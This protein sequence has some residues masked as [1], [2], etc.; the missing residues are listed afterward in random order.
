[1]FV[2]YEEID[3]FL[4]PEHFKTLKDLKLENVKKDEIKIYSNR[5][6]KNGEINGS[7][8]NNSLIQELFENYHN[9]AL[10]LLRKLNNN[11]IELWDYSEFHIIE[12]GSHYK[13]PIHRDSPFKILSG[14]I[15]ISPEI[16]KGTLLFSNMS[17][18]D[19]KE[20]LWEP[21]KALFFSRDENNSY[22]S[23][24]GDEKSTR[25]ALVYNLM[26]NNLKEVC[27][28]ENINFYKVKIR[29]FLNPYIHRIFKR[30]I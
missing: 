13:Y 28:I 23:Y 22:H 14:V 2:D 5:V 25:R 29:E 10:N 26:T 20:I 4:K 9:K 30:V 6:F 12:T 8:L 1:M 27:K 15:Y 19:K 18:K 3:G 7:C 11:K 16:N 21:N 24:E 17:G